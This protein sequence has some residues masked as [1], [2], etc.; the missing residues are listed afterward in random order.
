MSQ[1]FGVLMERCALIQARANLDILPAVTDG[2]SLSSGG[3]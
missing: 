1:S 3:T 2:D